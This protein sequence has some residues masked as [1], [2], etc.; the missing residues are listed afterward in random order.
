M[1]WG[2]GPA[3]DQGGGFG[4]GGGGG[5]C[6]GQGGESGVQEGGEEEGWEHCGGGCEKNERCIVDKDAIS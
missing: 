1:R 6:G 5:G 4:V 2:G 3:V